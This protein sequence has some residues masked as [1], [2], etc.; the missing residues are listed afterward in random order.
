MQV[1]RDLWLTGGRTAS[2]CSPPSSSNA[3]PRSR[4]KP[5]HVIGVNYYIHNQF[6][7]EG[8]MI[9]PSDARY[10]HVR[11]MLQEVHDR[12]RRPIF[13]AG[14]GIEDDTRPA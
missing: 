7:W 4:A 6:V 8:H 5:P 12:Y 9:V 10:R 2:P 13:V 3:S 14:R 11:Q 1:I